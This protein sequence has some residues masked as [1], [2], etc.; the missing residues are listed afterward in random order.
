MVYGVAVDL[1]FLFGRL[2]EMSRSHAFGEEA[3]GRKRQNTS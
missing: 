1:N 3:L 2:W